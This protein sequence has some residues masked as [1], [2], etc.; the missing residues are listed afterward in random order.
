MKGEKLT[1]T[2]CEKTSIME[3][4]TKWGALTFANNFQEVQKKYKV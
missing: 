4:K 2:M 1:T 3:Q